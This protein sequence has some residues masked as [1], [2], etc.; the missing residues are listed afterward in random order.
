MKIQGNSIGFKFPGYFT[1]IWNRVM[2]NDG[3]L[4]LNSEEIISNLKI[5]SPLTLQLL[6]S[7]LVFTNK[8]LE[9]WLYSLPLL[10]YIPLTSVY[11]AQMFLTEY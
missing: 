7:P 1:K 9:N 6:L 11:L 3:Q 8:H 4:A 5:N 10:F 2:I